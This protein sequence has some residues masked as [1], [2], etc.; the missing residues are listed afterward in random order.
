MK[1]KTLV[2]TGTFTKS[3]GSQ[4]TMKFV[5]FSDIPTVFRGNKSPRITGETETVY[6]VE[7]K[8]YRVFNNTTVIG[9]VSSTE[10]VVT[11]S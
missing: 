3:D 1:F 11:F 9:E 6:D 5:R 10:E 4:R 7:A 8:G 2:N